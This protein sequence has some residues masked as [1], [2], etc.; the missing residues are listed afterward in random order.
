M[1]RRAGRKSAR[2]LSPAGRLSGTDCD[3]DVRELITVES[4]V[5]TVADQ[6]KHQG[7]AEHD[8]GLQVSPRCRSRGA[9]PA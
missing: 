2:S 4:Y 9:V 8:V 3:P 5:A 1:A 7:V 6:G